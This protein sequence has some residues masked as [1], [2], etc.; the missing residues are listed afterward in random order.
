MIDFMSIF[1]IQKLKYEPAK[2]VNKHNIETISCDKTKMI[3][4]VRENSSRWKQN[5]NE[6]DKFLFFTTQKQKC[7]FYSIMA[8]FGS[9]C[10]WQFCNT[11]ST[12]MGQKQ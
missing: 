1:H 4:K 12:C 9:L 7:L 2:V 11:Q 6:P 5:K 10:A 3:R 8:Y